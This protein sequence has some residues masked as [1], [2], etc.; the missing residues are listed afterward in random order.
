MYYPFKCKDLFLREKLIKEKV[1]SPTW[2]RHVVNEVG[3][4]S[5][6]AEFALETVLLPIDQ[7]YSK[8]DMRVLSDLL[9]KNL[10]VT[11]IDINARI[12]CLEEFDRDYLLEK[13]EV[14]FNS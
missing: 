5:I 3:E 9:I 7:K 14:I 6:E 4:G 11:W 1:Y 8:N 10:Q 2:W 12:Y 13:L